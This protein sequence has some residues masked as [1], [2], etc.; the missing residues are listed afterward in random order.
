VEASPRLDASR[1][2][3]LRLAAFAATA[4]GALLMGIGS[5]LTW[6]TIGFEDEISIR[7]VS[8]GTDVAAGLFSLI[9]AVVILVLL[10]VSRAVADRVRRIIAIVIVALGVTT[11]GLAAWFVVSAP[12]HYSPVDDDRLVN[13]LAQ[14]THK[15]VEE[16]RTALASVID[17]LGGYTHVSPG[18]WIAI[19]GGM[20]AIAGGVL[21]LVWARRVGTTPAVADEA[22]APVA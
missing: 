8:P 11:T 9:A 22:S 4:L 2:S 17:Q 14:V 15:T 21:T 10:L 13:T 7:T 12:D 18:P 3:P 1:P 16:V 5:V 20:L 19:A 6:V